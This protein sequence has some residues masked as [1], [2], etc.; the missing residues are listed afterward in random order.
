[1]IDVFIFIDTNF[2]QVKN[3]LSHSVYL[4][5]DPDLTVNGEDQIKK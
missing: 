2:S 4:Q 1:M 5:T 3:V